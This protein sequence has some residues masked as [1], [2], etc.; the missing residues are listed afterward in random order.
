[1]PNKPK[2]AGKK[3]FVFAGEDRRMR[4]LFRLNWR[5]VDP[6]ACAVELAK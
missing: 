2:S 4:C 1:L 6:I 5:A 3:K